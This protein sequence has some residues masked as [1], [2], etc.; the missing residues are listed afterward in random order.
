MSVV[1]ALVLDRE[2]RLRVREA[3]DGRAAV[4]FC[5]RA[6]E[7]Y[8]TVRDERTAAAILELRDID[9]VSTVPLIRRLRTEFPLTAVI[10]YSS[11]HQATAQEILAAAHAGA[12]GLVIRGFDDIGVALRSAISAGEDDAFARRAIAGLEDLVTPA[13]RAILEYCLV[14]AR[15]APS[16][17]SL[18]TALGLHRKT[19]MN[20]LSGAGLPAPYAL[21]GWCR[22]LLAA[23]LLE[24]GGRPIERIAMT[25]G[26]PSAPSLRNMM[27]R[28]TGLQIRE[29][30]DAGGFEC[31]LQCMR[32]AIIAERTAASI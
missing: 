22:L 10:A 1:T 31:V 8:A 6:A 3:L 28:Y 11:M 25:L 4:R 2:T 5:Q 27:R 13:T 24:D 15:H 21:I 19:L 16:V 9:R 18:A 12:N 32:R 23:R 17:T 29:V 7:A 30:R 20:R 26:F 14:N